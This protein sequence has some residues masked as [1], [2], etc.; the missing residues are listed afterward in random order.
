MINVFILCDLFENFRKIMQQ[1]EKEVLTNNSTLLEMYVWIDTCL[2][3][4]DESN[5]FILHYYVIIIYYYIVVKNIKIAYPGI[6]AI[7]QL[8]FTWSSYPWSP[9]EITPVLTAFCGDALLSFSMTHYDITMGC[10][11]VASQWIM[12]LLGTSIVT[13]Q[14]VNDVAMCT[15]QC[16]MTLLWVSF[17][18]Y[19]YAKFW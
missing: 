16:I 4:S 11:I 7:L 19:Y 10:P 14:W 12:T 3:Y 5:T 8:V 15:S 1:R 2:H 9:V 6:Y 17:A 13:S 18:M